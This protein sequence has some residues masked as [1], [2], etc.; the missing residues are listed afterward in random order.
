MIQFR[1]AVANDV[2]CNFEGRGMLGHLS[3]HAW[4]R[5]APANDA[6]RNDSSASEAAG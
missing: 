2:D 5:G 4:R 6:S 3:H 1:V